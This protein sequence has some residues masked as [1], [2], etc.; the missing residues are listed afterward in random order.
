MKKIIFLLSI[1]FSINMIQAQQFVAT[2][3]YTIVNQLSSKEQEYTT[4]VD[5]I[6][7]SDD[8]DK[9][10]TLKV[11]YLDVLEDITLTVLSNPN[12][13]NIK[14]I[15]KVDI[16]YTSCCSSL[17]THYFMVTESDDY[18]FL[19]VIEN[20]YCEDASSEVQYIFPGQVSGKENTIVKAEVYDAQDYKV[21]QSMIWNDDE[22]AFNTSVF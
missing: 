6:T 19:P 1:L 3:K 8:P 16:Y 10:T 5:I 21:I 4:Y 9:I 2:D 18:I 13:E 14:E 17:E 12:I 22:L 7:T 11:S 15:I 20:T